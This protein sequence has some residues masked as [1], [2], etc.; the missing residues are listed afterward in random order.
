ML[1]FN[2]K[3]TL[4]LRG[5]DKATNFLVKIGFSYPA[6]SRFLKSKSQF[7]KVADIERLCLALNCTP[8][9]LFEWR[10]DANTVVAEN[11]ALR[12]LEADGEQKNLQQLVKDIPAE[13]LKKIEE[14]LEE[15]KS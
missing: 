12:G 4:A 1:L 11:H 6:A 2:P 10:Q 5:I 14:L 3:K 8:N 13:K 15:L 7:V 9:D